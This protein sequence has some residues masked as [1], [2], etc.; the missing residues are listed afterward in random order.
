MQNEAKGA[1]PGAPSG[2]STKPGVESQSAN[3]FAQVLTP[4]SPYFPCNCNQ[5]T[6]ALMLSSKCG[7]KG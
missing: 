2:Q 4:T 1:S 5:L 6:G 7:C 3:P